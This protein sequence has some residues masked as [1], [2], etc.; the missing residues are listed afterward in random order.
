MNKK[1]LIIPFP[2][3]FLFPFLFALL[4]GCSGSPER[5]TLK[6]DEKMIEAQPD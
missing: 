6:R 3:L 2:F 4:P 1:P 5:E